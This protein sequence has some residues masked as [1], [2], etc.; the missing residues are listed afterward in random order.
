MVIEWWKVSVVMP[1][2]KGEDKEEQGEKKLCACVSRFFSSVKRE[3]WGLFE[4]FYQMVG[5]S[6]YNPIQ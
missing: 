3:G 4:V 2:V 1:K 5:L 6:I